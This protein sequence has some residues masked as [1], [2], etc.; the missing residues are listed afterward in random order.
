MVYGMACVWKGNV[1]HS[2]I[3]KLK[4]KKKIQ[5]KNELDIQKYTSL[6]LPTET[7]KLTAFYQNNSI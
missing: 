6:N 1:M 3:Y 7:K 5:E 4:K 2:S